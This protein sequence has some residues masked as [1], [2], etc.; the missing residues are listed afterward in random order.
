MDAL[1]LIR[2]ATSSN[3]LVRL[4]G[5]ARAPFRFARLILVGVLDAGA[6]VGLVIIASRLI[7]ALKGLALAYWEMTSAPLRDI[8]PHAMRLRDC[9]K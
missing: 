4:Q 1:D 2:G 9:I 8:A 5:E 7:S 6:I 3:S